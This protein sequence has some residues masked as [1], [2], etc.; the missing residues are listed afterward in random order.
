MRGEI[1]SKELIDSIIRMSNDEYLNAT[2]EKVQNIM[3]LAIEELEKR[4]PYV[5]FDNVVF[6]PINETLNG[7]FTDNSV[8]E[9]F[10]GIDN[11]QLE[12]NSMRSDFWRKTKQRIIFAWKN[13]NAGKKKSRRQLK[14][15]AAEAQKR[16]IPD[17]FDPSRYNLSYLTEDL[18]LAVASFLN[19][20]SIVYREG[21]KIR[22]IGKNDF[23]SNTQ[24]LI[25]V[26]LY[27]GESFKYFINH[28]KGFVKINHNLR[29][30]ALH[31]K[32]DRVGT[33]LT[34]MI[35]VFNVL[36]YNINNKMP[37]QIFI[38]SLLCNCP[39][40]LFA[41]DAYT[42]FVKIIN[43]LTMTDVKEFHSIVEPD[44]SIFVDKFCGNL[45]YGYKKFLGKLIDLKQ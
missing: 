42:S 41:G 15:E 3:G 24:I 37:N 28:K 34:D 13:R 38:E 18:Q 5:S 32:L 27:N 35:K 39:D 23:G 33:N 20:T 8:L 31:D 4:I 30:S 22:I 12:I 43:Y 2:D 7:G 11:P 17:R 19:E 40:D 6:E 16:K 45:A 9:Y 14:K 29:V 26:V 21:N 1:L 25:H 44:K 36:Y 10:L